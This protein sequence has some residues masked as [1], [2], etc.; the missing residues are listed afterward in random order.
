MV[1]NFFNVTRSVKQGGPCSAYFFLCLAEVLAIQLRNNV[2]LEGI[3]VNAIHKLLGQYADD[4]DLYL[5][6][7]P[8]NIRFVFKTFEEFKGQSGFRIMIK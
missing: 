7:D 2:K 5:K 6:G 8:E 4:I 1:S 3:V